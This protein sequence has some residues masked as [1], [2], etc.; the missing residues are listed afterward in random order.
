M[1]ACVRACVSVC[2]YVC[3]SVCFPSVCLFVFL[4]FCLCMRVFVCLGLSIWGTAPH[5]CLWT[6]YSQYDH[7]SHLMFIRPSGLCVCWF[8]LC[9]FCLWVHVSSGVNLFCQFS[10]VCLPRFFPV[11]SLLVYFFSML[12]ISFFLSTVFYFISL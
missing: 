5:E 4:F 9:L 7:L 2:L 6:L 11:I 3:L 8:N 10:N 12:P 1:C